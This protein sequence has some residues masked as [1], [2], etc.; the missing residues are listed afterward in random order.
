MI[1]QALVE[2]YEDLL[3]QGRIAKPGW[4]KVKVSYGLNL[5]RQGHVLGLIPLKVAQ[6]TGGSKKKT[7]FVA[8]MMEVPHPEKRSVAVCPN[9]LCDNATY[10]LGV[11]EKGKPERTSQCYEACMEKH[12]E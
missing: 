9:F 1:L 12:M 10:I 4:G 5:D 3:K 8:R 2:H 6:E 7:V 11:D